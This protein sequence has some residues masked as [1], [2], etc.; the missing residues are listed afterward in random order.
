[1]GGRGGK[2]KSLKTMGYERY[3]YEHEGKGAAAVV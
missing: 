3:L 1:V 2:V